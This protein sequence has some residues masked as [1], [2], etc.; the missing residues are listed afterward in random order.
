MVNSYR[1]GDIVEIEM[2]I[3]PPVNISAIVHDQPKMHETKVIQVVAEV[4]ESSNLQS[5]IR[6]IDP[7][8]NEP[9][10]LVA[11]NDML[12]LS[13]KSDLCNA[14]TKCKHLKVCWE[15]TM[16]EYGWCNK[17]DRRIKGRQPFKQL[18]KCISEYGREQVL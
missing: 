13:L 7:A 10:T 9:V 3:A 11:S 17:Y 14:F 4:L 18:S 5:T 6:F 12:R 15:G 16:K 2:A 8:K 1:R